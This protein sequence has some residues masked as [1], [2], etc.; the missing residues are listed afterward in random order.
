MIKILKYFTLFLLFSGAYKS[1]AVV[2][3]PH[4]LRACLGDSD[5]T[6]SWV[7]P[8]D[9]CVSFSAFY[10]YGRVDSLSPF[11]IIDTVKN[12]SQSSYTHKGAKLVSQKWQYMIVTYTDCIGD[13]LISSILSVDETSPPISN[14]DSVSIDPMTG[15]IYIGWS[16]NTAPD[17]SGYNI[18][19][20]VGTSNTIA[21]TTAD[22][23]FIIAGKSIL[24]SAYSYRVSAFDSCGL[25]A[26]SPT[27]HTTMLLRGTMNDCDGK[28]ILNWSPYVGW[29]PGVAFYKI[30]VN[31]N[32]SGYIE[33]GQ[34]SGNIN[35]FELTG[36]LPGDSVS[37]YIRA[38]HNN[39]IYTS[40]SNLRGT[41]FPL[42]KRPRFNYMSNTT[43][44]GNN[45]VEIKWVADTTA[46][47]SRFVLLYGNDST[48]LD[49]LERIDFV[50]GQRNYQYTHQNID[51]TTLR[52]FYKILVMDDCGKY[53][54]SFSAVHS[55]IL[56]R[57]SKRDSLSNILRWNPYLH[58]NN[59]VGYYYIYRG[60]EFNG[61][62]KWDLIGSVGPSD[63]EFVDSDPGEEIGNTGLCYYI[64][65]FENEGNPYTFPDYLTSKSN[66]SCEIQDFTAFFP[67]ALN[68]YSQF[69]RVW[70]PKFTYV[71]F[72]KSTITIY[73]RW[74]QEII[75]LTNIK[76]GWDGKNRNGEYVP[77]DL[78]Y[79]IALLQGVNKKKKTE[80][81]MIYFMR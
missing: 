7:S 79:Y 10:I 21:G 56:L 14:I 26:A 48:Q 5:I 53:S 65:A 55:P 31:R 80:K 30:M 71:N 28:Y 81:G 61:Q 20:S 37:V 40:S 49:T 16:K 50:G 78:Y 43:I 45:S 6:I 54:G 33:E 4:M 25:Q 1:Q 9:V 19:Q 42:V 63:S 57:V 47:I 76:K 73:N 2:V 70:L 59:L 66:Y 51:V 75:T 18:I 44:I 46:A 68:I 22:T 35:T 39:N 3:S 34:T 29:N 58:W 27:G 72:D 52:N 13:T 77:P 11:T 32:N 24:D 15:E 60:G 23:F 69:N 62:Y 12:L 41:L 36:F 64:E 8:T 38:L 67:N 74:G 17:I